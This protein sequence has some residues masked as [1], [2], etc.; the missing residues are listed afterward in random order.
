MKAEM[1]RIVLK[2]S[3]LSPNFIGAWN[4]QP[5][6]VCDELIDYFEKHQEDQSIGST[7]SGKNLNTKDRVDISVNP[8]KLNL[9][10]N[11]V[12]NTYITGLFECYK[13][14]LSQWPFL[15]SIGKTIEIGAF[16]LG[17]YHPGQHFQG[18]HAERSSLDTLHRVFAWM[19]YLNDV[20]KGGETFFSHYDLKIKPRKGLTIIWPAEWTHAHKGNVLL[21]GSKYMIT[22]WMNFPK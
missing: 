14:Y 4:I 8:K 2:E 11:E 10:G 6:S 18:L 13:D 15:E 12:F 1:Q 7:A 5:F 9:P 16:N 21:E 22:G 17:R 19:T 20:D 3:N